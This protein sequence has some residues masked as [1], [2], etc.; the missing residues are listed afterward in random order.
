MVIRTLVDGGLIMEDKSKKRE[1]SV[2]LTSAN[3]PELA[4]KI[5][6]AS[7]KYMVR[8]YNIYK[9]LENK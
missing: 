9:A 3:S 5:K 6:E 7:K 4:R 1:E 2:V 8:N